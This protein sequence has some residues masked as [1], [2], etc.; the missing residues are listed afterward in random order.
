MDDSFA[1]HTK[2]RTL[3]IMANCSEPV[4]LQSS[5]SSPTFSVT[6]LNMDYSRY[7]ITIRCSPIFNNNKIEMLNFP[8]SDES[9]KLLWVC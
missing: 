1:H 2:V 6:G 5:Y 7:L 3:H 4:H 8:P 9:K